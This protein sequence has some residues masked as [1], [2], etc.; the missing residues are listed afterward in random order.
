MGAGRVLVGILIY[1][2]AIVLIIIFVTLEL[3]VDDISGMG[4]ETSLFQ[5]IFLTAL[6]PYSLLIINGSWSIIAAIATGAFIGGLIAKGTKAGIAVG[7]ISFGILFLLQICV[8]FVFNFGELMAWYG[9]LGTTN[10]ILDV[11]I[12]TGVSI[13]CGAI[14]GAITSD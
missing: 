11:T 14:G 7:I 2:I 1:I 10:V 3:S 9:P 13:V 4:F 8:T 12:G 5:A 6:H